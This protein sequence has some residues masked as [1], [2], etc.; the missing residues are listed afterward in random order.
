MDSS[1]S[2]LTPSPREISPCKKPNSMAIVG[3]KFKNNEVFV[4]EMLVSVRAVKEAMRLHR[5]HAVK[6][7]RIDAS[8]TPPRLIQSS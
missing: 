7:D 8:A 1:L 3:D 2:R 5:L 6:Y 4:P